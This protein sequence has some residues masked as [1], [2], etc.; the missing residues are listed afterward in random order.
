MNIKNIVKI[1]DKSLKD[2]FDIFAGCDPIWILNFYTN[3]KYLS[4]LIPRQRIIVSPSTK[5]ELLNW[6][7]SDAF[8]SN[9]M[10]CLPYIDGTASEKEMLKYAKELIYGI[11]YETNQEELKERIIS[12]KWNLDK[13]KL[14]IKEL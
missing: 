14:I 4:S 9:S 8:S 3:K 2:E 7:K 12:A 11:E 6:V 1:I 13:T 10:G 5:E